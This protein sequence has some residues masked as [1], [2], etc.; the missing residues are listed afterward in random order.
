[1][2]GKSL[3]RNAIFLDHCRHE[4]AFVSSFELKHDYPYT[5]KD[6]NNL[7]KL[8]AIFLLDFFNNLWKN[9]NKTE[10]KKEGI[11][12]KKD[13]CYFPGSYCLYCFEFLNNSI[14][15]LSRLYNERLRM[16][17]DIDTWVGSETQPESDASE[18]VE[19]VK[20]CVEIDE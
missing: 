10:I 2:V 7:V 15:E 13:F 19:P 9:P 17:E 6:L 4:N 16:N 3:R 5:E 1:T 12:T 8:S 20:E 18:D 11:K 14:E